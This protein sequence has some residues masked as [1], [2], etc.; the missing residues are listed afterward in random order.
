VLDLNVDFSFKAVSS[1]EWL[2]QIL[3]ASKVNS[4]ALGMDSTKNAQK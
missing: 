2:M 3:L 1:A 4:S